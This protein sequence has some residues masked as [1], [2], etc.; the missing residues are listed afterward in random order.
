LKLVAGT[1]QCANACLFGGKVQKPK[2]RNKKNKI[3]FKN[4]STLEFSDDPNDLEST[5]RGD[6]L[7]NPRPI[8]FEE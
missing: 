8:V 5:F 1:A 6:D 3:E 2:K 4:G 7:P